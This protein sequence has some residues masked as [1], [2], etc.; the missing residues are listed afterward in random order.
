MMRD[1]ILALRVQL[2]IYQ[3]AVTDMKEKTKEPMSEECGAE[4]VTPCWETK[5]K[6]KPRAHHMEKES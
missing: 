5:T 4:K 6:V 2:N 3:S 1:E